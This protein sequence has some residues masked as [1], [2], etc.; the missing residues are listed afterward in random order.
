MGEGYSMTP[1]SISGFGFII[2]ACLLFVF[3]I[4]TTCVCGQDTPPP[5]ILHFSMDN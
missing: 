1:E 4:V 3:G 2:K 5:F